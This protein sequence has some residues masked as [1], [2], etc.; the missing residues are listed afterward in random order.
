MNGSDGPP[1]ADVEQRYVDILKQLNWPNPY[2]SSA[3]AKPTTVTGDTGV[4]MTGPYEYVAPSYW[5]SDKQY[6]GAHGF[7]TETSP[8]PAVPPVDSLI[9]M[10]PSDHRWPIDSWWDY[11]AG[12]S[13]FR[14]LNVF[15]EAMNVRYGAATNL[16]DYAMKAQVMAYEGERAMFEAFGRN[17]YTSTGVIQWMLNNAWPSTIWHLYD[18]YLR[19]GG[20]Y[21][22]AKKACEPLHIQYSY[23]DRSIVVVNSFYT[24]FQGLKAAVKVYNLDMTV[25]YSQEA[26][27]DIP[28]DGV[29]KVFTIPEISGLTSTYFVDLAL[30]DAGGKPVS[31]NFYWLSTKPDVLDWDKSTWYFTPTKSF[32]DLTAL[33][34]LLKV[35]LNVTSESQIDGDYGTTRVTVENP[36]KV[37]AFAVHLKVMKPSRYRDPESENNELEVLPVIWQDNY[38]PLRPGEKREITATYRTVDLQLESRSSDTP[39]WASKLGKPTVDVDGW[40]VLPASTQ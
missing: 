38:F 21:F 20:G 5:L 40:N 3:M 12:G 11:H 4:K 24:D 15:T 13:A 33:K 29:Q 17:K 6:G 14:N 34:T 23:D 28:A 22:G 25:K 30:Q 10:L 35:K 32:S 18:Y 39:N 7:N 2:E 36:S 31:S 1:P 16:A 9:R 26:A 8:G 19:P 27:L 37:L